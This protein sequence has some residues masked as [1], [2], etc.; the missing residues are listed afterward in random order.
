MTVCCRLSTTTE[1][2]FLQH[3]RQRYAQKRECAGHNP[4]LCV[5]GPALYQQKSRYM[6][7]A[8]CACVCSELALA[9]AG[10]QQPGMRVPL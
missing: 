1:R 3:K 9:S 7:L 2:L 5:E 4:C 8:P 6:V 10:E